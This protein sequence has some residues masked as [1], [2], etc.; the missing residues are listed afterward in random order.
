MTE[1]YFLHSGG[2]EVQMQGAGSVS[3]DRPPL[4]QAC[5]C[6]PT[7]SVLTLDREGVL[8]SLSLTESLILPD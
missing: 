1:M 8:V 7:H 2:W 4:L 5:R 6:L 3:V